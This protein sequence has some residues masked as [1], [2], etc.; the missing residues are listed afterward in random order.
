MLLDRHLLGVLWWKDRATN[1]Q[2]SR[3]NRTSNPL[4]R[5]CQ[6]IVVFGRQKWVYLR[7]RVGPHDFKCLPA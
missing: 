2:K 6:I 3:G 1:A 7:K 5:V 4:E